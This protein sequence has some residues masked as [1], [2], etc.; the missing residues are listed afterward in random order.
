M[1]EA[2]LLTVE[3]VASEF[4][5]TSQTI[6][7]WI[8]AGTLPALRIGHVYRVKRDHVDAL[9][10]RANADSESSAIPRDVWSG[11]VRRLPRRSGA[12]EPRSVWE[13]AGDPAA[14]AKRH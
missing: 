12:S 14:L 8:K 7:N 1:T 5:L 3:Q 9:L 6:R 2:Q 11:S 10:D 4:Q 13:G